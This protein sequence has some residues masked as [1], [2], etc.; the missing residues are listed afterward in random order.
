MWISVAGLGRRSSPAPVHEAAAVDI[1]WTTTSSELIGNAQ[2]YLSDM[3]A[4]FHAAM[5]VCCGA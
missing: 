5:G 3:R 2:D 1:I 4:A